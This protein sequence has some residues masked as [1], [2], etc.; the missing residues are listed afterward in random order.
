MFAYVGNTTLGPSWS[1]PRWSADSGVPECAND[2]TNN[3]RYTPIVLN[4]SVATV[5]QISVVSSSQYFF[6]AFVVNKSDPTALFEPTADPCGLPF[7]TPRSL[8]KAL[9]TYA[10]GT[11]VND[12][13]YLAIGFY[14]LVITSS[15]GKADAFAGKHLA[16]VTRRVDHP[17][18][19][20][21]RHRRCLDDRS[22]GAR[23]VRPVRASVV[24]QVRQ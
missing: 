3:S 10:G 18:G 11:S 9:R 12:F 8:G 22:P 24:L 7:A 16:C 19:D 6:T 5:Y 17:S 13:V 14:D 1:Y 4:I 2:A 20:H 23:P 15:D 21:S